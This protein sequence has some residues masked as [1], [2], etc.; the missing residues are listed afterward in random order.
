DWNGYRDLVADG[1]TGYLVPTFMVRG[2]TADATSRLLTL[3][4]GNYDE[5][6]AECNQAVA[7]DVAGAAE[8]YRRLI[9]DAELRRVLG[10]AGRERVLR[11][12]TWEK[13]VRAYEELWRDQERERQSWLAAGAGRVRTYPGPAASPAPEH[14]FAGYPTELLEDAAPVGAVAGAEA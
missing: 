12:Y 10:A 4:E 6:L 13:V 14:T 11:Q 5:F 9:L 1:E 7:V 3:G 2:A 8:G